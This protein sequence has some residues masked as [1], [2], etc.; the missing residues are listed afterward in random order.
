MSAQLKFGEL[1]GEVFTVGDHRPVCDVRGDT[2]AEVLTYGR[3]IVRRWNAHEDLLAALTETLD[4]LEYRLS[5]PSR[6]PVVARAR[7]AIAKAG[8]K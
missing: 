2:D 5:A 7:A 4:S 8:G 6:D 3:E 1:S